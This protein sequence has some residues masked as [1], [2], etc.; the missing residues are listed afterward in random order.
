MKRFRLFAYLFLTLILGSCSVSKYIPEGKIYL[1][2]A[3][4]FKGNKHFEDDILATKVLSQENTRILGTKP[5]LVAWLIGESIKRDSLLLLKK[6]ITK[7][8]RKK[9]ILGKIV[10]FLQEVV[11]EP[12]ALIEKKLLE[13]DIKN[14]DNFY[15]SKGFFEASVYAK[16]KIF[17]KKQGKVVFL[18]TEKEPFRYLQIYVRTQ[19]S[20]TKKIVEKSL[21]NSH[22]KIGQIYDEELLDKERY[23]ITE[24]LQEN[25]FYEFSPAYVNYLVDTFTIDSLQQ[26]LLKLKSLKSSLHKAVLL[27]IKLPDENIRYN[28]KKLN[29]KILD[30]DDY[31]NVFEIINLPDSCNKSVLG[32]PL[33]IKSLNLKYFSK[34][35]EVCPPDLF[36]K[37]EYA[38]TAE[39]LTELGIFSSI[40]WKHNVDEEKKE[41]TSNLHVRLRQRWRWE[42]GIEG[43]QSED[44]QLNSNLPGLGWNFKLNN[45]NF[46]KKGEKLFLNNS[47]NLRV[48]KPTPD[49]E[50]KFYIQFFSKAELFFPRLLIPVPLLREKPSTRFSVSYTKDVREEYKRSNF[51]S[52]FS[53]RGIR[54]IGED[55]ITEEIFSPLEVQ[56]VTSELSAGFA[57]ILNEL[58]ATIRDFVRRDYTPRVSSSGEFSL[59]YY[60]GFYARKKFRKGILLRFTGSLGGNAPYLFD[61]FQNKVLEKGD[62]NLQDGKIENLYE[63]GMFTKI[64]GEIRYYRSLTP[65]TAVVGRLLSGFANPHYSNKTIPFEYRFFLG[66]LNDMRGWQSNTLGPGTFSPDSISSLITPGGNALLCINLELR[67]KLNSLIEIAA[68]GDLGNV[69]FTNNDPFFQDP[70]GRVFVPGFDAGLGLRLDLEYFIVRLDIAQQIYTP[71]KQDFVVRKLTH[72]GGTGLQ[73]NF[74][75]GYPF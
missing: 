3:P 17:K 28:V 2:R 37:S 27:Y 67:Q 48:Y 72:I 58:P 68:F 23:R 61:W 50:P 42:A 12:P 55:K 54:R 16:V 6:L 20:L 40:Y 47:A 24:H 53:F 52:N 26:S 39:R 1:A 35:I 22:L 36:R 73:Y 13:E 60:K 62:G 19:D 45:Y 18:I 4:K 56:I 65:S 32:E 74:G 41:I 63:Y 75:I 46:L 44:R 66:G 11:G 14:L 21:K 70:R 15:F 7:I 34:Q 30:S 25:G 33:A 51:T 69:W 9:I 43:F 71:D 5:Y 59:R 38:K 57:N 64:V 10:H 29:I 49:A 8:D 31:K